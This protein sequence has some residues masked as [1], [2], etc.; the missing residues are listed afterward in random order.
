MSKTLIVMILSLFVATTAFADFL[1]ESDSLPPGGVS[2]LCWQGDDP[3]HILEKVIFAGNS[4]PVLQLDEHSCALVG[5]DLEQPPGHWPLTVESLSPAGERHLTHLALR[6][7]RV[8]RPEQR[9]TLPKQ[10]VT[11]TQ[12][13]IV[14][15]IE[16]DQKRLQQIFARRSQIV[17]SPPFYRPVDGDVISTFGLRRVLNGIAKSPHNGVDFRA[18]TGTPIMAMARGEVVLAEDLYYTGK[19]II[20][21]HGGGFFSLYAHLDRILVAS[22][23]VAESGSTIGTVGS[24]GRSTGPHLHLGTRLGQ[25]RV[26]PLAV[27]SLFTGE[28][29]R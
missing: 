5:V 25:A 6:V 21:D 14:K 23:T 24:T 15:Q 11:P 13:K 20:L 26:D 10:M 7:E 1:L 9:L 18:A 29:K 27:I 16:R 4:L 28:K 22:N 12:K 3:P 8:V 19:T 2:S 17:F